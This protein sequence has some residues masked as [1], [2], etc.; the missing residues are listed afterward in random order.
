MSRWSL[1]ALTVA[2]VAAV[3]LA[4][5]ARVV[6]TAP[7]SALPWSVFGSSGSS[8]SSLNYEL[9]FT[10]ASGGGSSSSLNYD[11]GFTA[12]QSSPIGL[13]ES[14]NFRLGAGFWYGASVAQQA[15]TPPP[16]EADLAVSKTDSPDPVTAGNNLTYTITVTN[17]GPLDAT[18]VTVTEP[19]PMGVA[20]VSATPSQGS[21]SGT[22]FVTCNLGTI[23][24]GASATVTIVGVPSASVAGTTVSN[25]AMVTGNE[26][27]PDGSN[28]SAT[29]TTTV[30][31]PAQ[32]TQNLI[33][34]VQALV[35]GVLDQD[36]ADDLI[37]SLQEAIEELTEPVPEPDEACELLQE[38]IADVNEL[39]NEGDLSPAQGQPLIDAAN[40]IIN[41]LSC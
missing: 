25:T 24:N 35:P 29:A 4:L 15:V 5:G 26:P 9:D 32:A 3:V 2:G 10:V 21:C 27:D 33:D 23:T 39:I 11:L 34:D 12:G 19:L 37:E 22:S 6:L 38:F 30:H 31:T 36:Q 20:P 28:N 18:G 8:S 1:L 17:N 14:A 40:D 16:A 41:V 7:D 13:Y